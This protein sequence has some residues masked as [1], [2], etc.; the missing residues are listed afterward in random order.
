[1]K[2]QK[3]YGLKDFYKDFER[4]KEEALAQQ[5]AL[6]Q[7]ESSEPFVKQIIDIISKEEW[8]KEYHPLAEAVHDAEDIFERSE[9]KAKEDGNAMSKAYEKEAWTALEAADTIVDAFRE[10]TGVSKLIA[11]TDAYNIVTRAFC[12]RA[13]TTLVLKETSKWN[14]QGQFARLDECER[15]CAELRQKV[16]G[17][18][19]KKTHHLYQCAGGAKYYDEINFDECRDTGAIYW[20]ERMWILPNGK[21]EDD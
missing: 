9:A 3:T 11:L 7:S 1:M 17:R 2:E 10:R 20:T 21:T 14:L 19:H 12:D 4:E 16:L 13:I 18:G 8:Q 5:N 15:F 6:Y